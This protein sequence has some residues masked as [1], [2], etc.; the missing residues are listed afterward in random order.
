[1]RIAR[2][3]LLLVVVAIVVTVCLVASGR[4]QLTERWNP[5]APLRIDAPP[6]AF[7]RFKLARASTDHAACIELLKRAEL[8]FR[9]LPDRVA[10][11][12]CGLS[13]AVRVHRTSVQIGAPLDMSCRLALSLALWERNGLQP[14]AHAHFG[15]PAARL[16]HLGSY[17]CRNVG[18]GD[19][20]RRSQ[21]ATADALDV[22]GF[23]LADGRQV[24]V[25]RDW[26]DDGPA[27]RFLREVFAAGC[28]HFDGALGP[29]YNAA[30]RDHFHFDRASFRV[31]R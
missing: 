24:T 5:W 14:A 7:F 8:R 10:G 9:V 28:R 1:M 4:L 11:P 20:G 6:D 30:H 21:H 27:G 16:R 3:S 19:G 13:Q 17:A 26:D 2:P 18:G 23:V 15:V 12:G 31:C 29:A 25:A 22:A